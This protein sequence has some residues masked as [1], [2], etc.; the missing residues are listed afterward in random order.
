MFNLEIVSSRRGV[1]TRCLVGSCISWRLEP[2]S[3]PRS[4]LGEVGG[5]QY[6]QPGWLEKNMDDGGH[7]SIN[8][9]WGYQ[10][11]HEILRIPWAA[12]GMSG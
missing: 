11:D 4:T 10:Y 3:R 6:L 7:V 1:R 2:C 5:L 12:H 8:Q 9:S